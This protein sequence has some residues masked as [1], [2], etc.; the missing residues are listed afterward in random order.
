MRRRGIRICSWWQVNCYT[1]TTWGLF[2]ISDRLYPIS[3]EPAEMHGERR[4]CVRAA[5]EN[6]KHLK[7]QKFF[8]ETVMRW[9][10]G[11]GGGG[12]GELF[13]AEGEQV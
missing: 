9:G 5:S 6:F 12:G 13:V 3:S 8:T 7:C 1:L 2:N 4:E 10:G 11:G